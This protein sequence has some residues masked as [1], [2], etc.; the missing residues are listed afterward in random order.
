MPV[1]SAFDTDSFAHQNRSIA[2]GASAMRVASSCS[3]GVNTP[4][5][6]SSE[7]SRSHASTSTPTRAFAA[8]TAT[9]NWAVCAMAR[10]ILDESRSFH[11]P[12]GCGLPLSSR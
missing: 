6:N 7:R 8:T 3:S 2:L 1:P 9:T 12:M 4:R 5:V 10:S 11:L